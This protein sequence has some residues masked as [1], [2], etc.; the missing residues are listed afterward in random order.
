MIDNEEK[1][2]KAQIKYI[3]KELEQLRYYYSDITDII[4]FYAIRF[5]CFSYT[6]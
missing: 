6:Q 4:G 3:Q 1:L 5:S 2:K